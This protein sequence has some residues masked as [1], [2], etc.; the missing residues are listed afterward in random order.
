MA[1]SAASTLTHVFGVEAAHVEVDARRSREGL[2]IGA[3]GTRTE[4]SGEVRMQTKG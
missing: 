2:R 4:E 3:Y 1:M